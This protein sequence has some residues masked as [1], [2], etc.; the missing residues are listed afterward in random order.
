MYHVQPQVLDTK[1]AT[2]WDWDLIE[3]TLLVT[4]NLDRKRM[5][6]ATTQRFCRRLLQHLRPSAQQF[7]RCDTEHRQEAVCSLLRVLLSCEDGVKVIQSADFVRD[8]MQTLETCDLTTSRHFGCSATVHM[9]NTYYGFVATLTAFTV[10][11]ELIEA[12]QGNKA[13]YRFCDEAMPD[14][15]LALFTAF[16]E[17]TVDGHARVILQVRSWLDTVD[18]SACMSGSSHVL[19]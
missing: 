19:Q 18:T 9:V 6:S 15:H 3:S 12:C 2:L 17:P 10:G 13:L 16:L 14:N 5:E 1:D 7:V 8:L 4:A 11:V